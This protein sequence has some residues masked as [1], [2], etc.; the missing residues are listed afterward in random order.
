MSRSTLRRFGALLLG[1]T[2]ALTGLATPAQ[3]ASTGSI[4][5]QLTDGGAAVTGGSVYLYGDDVD[6]WDYAWLDDQG[7]YAFDAVPPGQY[8]VSFEAWGHPT[9]F[10]YG[11]SD[12]S[13]AN[14]ITVTAGGATVVND[15]LLPS[16]TITGRLVDRTGA[17]APFVFVSAEATDY[18]SYGYGSTGP[19]GTFD[20]QVVP[21][22]YRV[23]F[24]VGGF[25]QFAYGTLDSAAA[26]VFAVTAGGTVTVND[27]LVATGTVAGRF[28]DTSG[29]PLSGVDVY[30][31]NGQFF[32]SAETDE[33]GRYRLDAV[34][35]GT[36]YTVHF[37]SSA[38]FL[39]QYAYG[40]VDESKAT[41]FA[42]TEGGTT[43]VD[44]QRLPT[45]SVRL[46]A[47]DSRT[48]QPILNFTSGL[49]LDSRDSKNGEV[50]Y[51][52]VPVGTHEIW[53][54]A[55]GYSFGGASVTVVAGEQADVR[56]VMEPLARIT[57]TVV[58][59][60]TGAP[61]PGVCIVPVLVD[62]VR[63]PDGCDEVTDAN[64]K[65]T[66]MFWR[67]AGTYQLLAWPERAKG[68]GAQWLG[69]RGGTGDLRRAT[70]FTVKPGEAVTPPVIR[71]D[72]AGV[73]TGQVFGTDGAALSQGSVRIAG[74]HPGLGS[75]FGAF[76]IGDGG[77]YRIDKLGPYEWPLLFDVYGQQATQWS[78]GEAN[79]DR[80]DRIAVVAGGTTTYD[81]RLEAGVSV[82][83]SSTT[84]FQGYV[85]ARNADT[86][87]IVGT[88]WLDEP[89]VGATRQLIGGQHI[90]FEYDP[91]E[92]G[93][94]FV[95]GDS[96]ASATKY[97]VHKHKDG[98]FALT[99]G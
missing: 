85:L 45:G 4:T 97:K 11:K 75:S 98:A 40:A 80:A 76:A 16:G 24:D 90:R 62:E 64:G 96:F 48:G 65:I 25:G 35:V 39:Q 59:A 83:V 10:A 14:L 19:D 3:A 18:S 89:N 63:M 50:I 6:H 94:R 31:S 49:G 77:R 69:P 43:T 28:T 79:R 8:R 34:P 21:G 7:R 56:L 84:P 47:V 81:Y 13:S 58:D 52:T 37:Y 68:Y 22:K 38:L 78:G 55:S 61:L 99:L 95:G 60:A 36:G 2:L 9:Q 46:T 15:E 33:D 87:D 26:A 57:A 32:G 71:M 12:W 88:W 20:I 41:R 93:R 42:V 82:T 51:P 86:G 54:N 29:A 74:S 92:G 73:I 1:V 70:T 44:D 5:G 27:T 23:R 17:P 66:Q 67:G 53:A 30:V 91:S 72:R